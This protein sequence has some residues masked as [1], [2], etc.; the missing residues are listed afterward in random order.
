MCERRRVEAARTPPANYT[1]VV[2]PKPGHDKQPR[3][4]PA[5]PEQTGERTAERTGERTGEQTA[6]RTAERTDL[7]PRA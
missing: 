4:A 6:E 1:N 5:H 2:P 3:P 7:R